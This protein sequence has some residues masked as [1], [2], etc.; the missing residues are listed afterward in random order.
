MIKVLAAHLD[1]DHRD[2]YSRAVQ[3]ILATNLAEITMAQLVD[4]LPKA[5]IAWQAQGSFLCR[6]HPLTDHGELCEGVLE[7]TQSLRDDLNLD[8][9]SFESHVRKSLQYS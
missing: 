9:L 8:T 7:K 3:A 2:A 4:G 1:A 6:S 5:E